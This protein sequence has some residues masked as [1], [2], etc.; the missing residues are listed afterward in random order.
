MATPH[1]HPHLTLEHAEVSAGM[2]TRLAIHFDLDPGWHLYWNGRNDSGFPITPTLAL[3]EGWSA[4]D[5][6]WPAPERHISEGD[7]LDHIYSGSA[8]LIVPVRIGAETATG[9]ATLTCMLD[10]V[11][12]RDMCVFE[13]DT[14]SLEVRVAEDARLTEDADT[15]RLFERTDS[16]IPLPLPDGFVAWQW[17]DHGVHMEVPDA[18]ALAFFPGVECAEMT[19]PIEDAE[20]SSNRLHLR[21]Q[22]NERENRRL[23][24]VLQVDGADRT[25]RWFQLDVPFA[26]SI[27]AGRKS[28]GDS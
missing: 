20:S 7:I 28:E 21:F 5:A 9:T 25:T 1:A 8:T 23:A 2:E 12:C 16:R 27:S 6:R 14:L 3:P 4:G 13:G 15:R 22:E 18:R 24:G 26:T 11:A 17:E 19:H 10:W